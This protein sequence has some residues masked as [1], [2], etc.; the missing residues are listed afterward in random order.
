MISEKE[1]EVKGFLRPTKR[2]SRI[3][4]FLKSRHDYW[5]REGRLQTDGSFFVANM[6]ITKF[7][8]LPRRTIQRS[9]KH[10]TKIG[11]IRYR[12]EP[13]RGKATYYWLTDAKPRKQPLDSAEI[14]QS[15]K[16]LGKERTYEGLINGG[17]S[18]EE[19]DTA[20]KG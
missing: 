15:L 1:T 11:W 10:L 16:S 20:L 18:Q 14:K 17:Y 5:Q 6:E 8:K 13:G 4:G 12:A 7:L 3:Y 2:E 19:I 9:K